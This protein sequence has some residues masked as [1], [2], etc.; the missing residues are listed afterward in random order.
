MSAKKIHQTTI[1][2][3]L[4][5]RQRQCCPTADNRNIEHRA[6]SY[7]AAA[8]AAGRRKNQQI[9]LAWTN[10]SSPFDGTLGATNILLGTGMVLADPASEEPRE[11]S[12]ACKWP[13]L[14][15][16][17]VDTDNVLIE[18]PGC[19]YLAPSNCESSGWT[20]RR[21]CRNNNKMSART[22]KKEIS[23]SSNCLNCLNAVRMG[24]DGE[25]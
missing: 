9:S 8:A 7:T 18:S 1:C 16:L 14:K 15:S 3:I 2:L 11:L 12:Q 21:S 20:R 5:K 22:E 4:L 23:S 19:W 10:K 25:S 13:W 17:L 24:K 6:S